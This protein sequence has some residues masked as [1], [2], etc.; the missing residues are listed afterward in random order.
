MVLDTNLGK[1]VHTMII[2]LTMKAIIDSY[3]QLPSLKR[4]QLENY[5]KK[6]ILSARRSKIKK[7]TAVLKGLPVVYQMPLKLFSMHLTLLS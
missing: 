7:A 2:I 5:E 3:K 4:N 1:L 6:I